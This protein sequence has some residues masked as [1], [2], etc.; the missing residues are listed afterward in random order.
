MVLAAQALFFCSSRSEPPFEL[1]REGDV[2][3]LTYSTDEPPVLNPYEIV[4]GTVFGTDQS[5]ETYLFGSAMAAGVADDGTVFIDDNRE[6]KIYRF[7]P[8]GKHLAS[9]GRGG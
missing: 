4:A 1:M 9:F 7:S 8:E 3:V 5:L 2:E 6:H